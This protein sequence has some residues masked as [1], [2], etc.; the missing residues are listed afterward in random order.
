MQFWLQKVLF[1][2][3]V[4]FEDGVSV[5]PKKVEAIKDWPQP[6]NVTEVRSII[7]LSRYYKRFMEGL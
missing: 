1:F 3:H 4:I 7:G 2:G 6:T 5:D